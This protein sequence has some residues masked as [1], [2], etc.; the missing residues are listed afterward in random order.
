MIDYLPE[1]LDD[2]DAIESLLDQVFGPARLLKKSYKFRNRI[3]P[4]PALC[5]V[6]YDGDRLVGTIRYWPLRVGPH[7]VPAV[8]LGPLGVAPERRGEGIG[9][10]LVMRTMEL[11]RQAGIRNILLVG[12][13]GYYARFGFEP[14]APHGY[15]MPGEDPKRLQIEPLLPS[16]LTEDAGIL[17]PATRATITA[18]DA[19]HPTWR[20]ADRAVA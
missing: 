13:L 15:R 18:L 12:D 6:A 20:W 16:A 7:G 9:V 19:E 2:K 17:R 8:L 11:A 4:V 5:W 10:T 14:A 3:P 1:A